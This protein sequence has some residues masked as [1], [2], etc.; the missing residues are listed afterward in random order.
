MILKLKTKKM[1]TLERN[2][3]EALKEYFDVT[4]INISALV[5]KIGLKQVKEFESVITKVY[6]TI[7]NEKSSSKAS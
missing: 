1:L 6:K 5:K 4:T 3:A 7:E 2:E